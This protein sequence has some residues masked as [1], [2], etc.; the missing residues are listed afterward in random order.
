MPEHSDKWIYM[1]AV[2]SQR[3]YGEVFRHTSSRNF[4]QSVVHESPVVCQPLDPA[5]SDKGLSIYGL[6]RK[7]I[8]LVEWYQNNNNNIFAGVFYAYL[9]FKPFRY[10]MTRYS[11]HNQDPARAVYLF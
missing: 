11:L 7:I 4:P 1:L 2:S 9:L 3:D 5:T 8:M 6:V 10:L